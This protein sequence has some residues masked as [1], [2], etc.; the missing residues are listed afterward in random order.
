MMEDNNEQQQQPEQLYVSPIASPMVE[1]KSLKYSVKLIRQAVAVERAIRNN[2][3][4]QA[5]PPSS[6]PPKCVKRGV[7]E[8][9]KSLRKGEKGLVFFASD[10]FPV[11]IISHLPV[12]CEEKDVLYG[13]IG[14]KKYVGSA[15]C[16]SR[17]AS[18]LFVCQPG[19]NHQL[20]LKDGGGGEKSGKKRKAKEMAEGEEAEG[21]KPTTAKEGE[22]D[23]VVTYEEFDSL[24]QKTKKSV[25]KCNPYF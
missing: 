2:R 4:Q 21:K 5:T 17:P 8:V 23:V 14:S 24:F 25:K 9:T 12:L 22:K 15:C 11:D 10:V 6:A 3:K 19:E 16:S 20:A 7:Q 18:V 1:G 13:Y